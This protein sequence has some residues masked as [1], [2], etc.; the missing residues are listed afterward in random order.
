MHRTTVAAV[1]VGLAL[2]AGGLEQFSGMAGTLWVLILLPVAM[3]SW[4]VGWRWGA[5]VGCLGA[6]LGMLVPAGPS[7]A[8]IGVRMALVVAFALLTETGRSRMEVSREPIRSDPSTGLANGR[9]LLDSV[10][11]EVERAQ[12]YGRPFTVAY[13]AV[14]N[15]PTVRHRSGEAAAEEVMRRIAHHIR[16]SLRGVD[17]AARLRGREF[18]LL[19]P[20]TGVDAARSVLS[21]IERSLSASLAD[22]PLSVGFSIGAVTWISSELPVKA[23][24]QRTYQLMYAA[25]QA[26][27]RLEHEVLDTA[28]PEPQR[29]PYLSVR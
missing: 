3:A 26:G 27:T 11:Q 23:L 24:H 16:G 18:A 4:Y 1:C 22:D 19:L 17:L 5:A 6:G 13:V 25:R 20:E 10:G 2:I 9:A 28:L 7:G 29:V 15:L 21:R 8:E 14:E 12:R